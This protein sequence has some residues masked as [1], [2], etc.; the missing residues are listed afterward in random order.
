M[1]N[2]L[3]RQDDQSVELHVA[4]LCLLAE[5]FFHFLGLPARHAQGFWDLIHSEQINF[6]RL[7][8]SAVL[9]DFTVY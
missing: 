2:A 4:L 8:T 9:R 7:G 1:N 5:D 6:L 3:L